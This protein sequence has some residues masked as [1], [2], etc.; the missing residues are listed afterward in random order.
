NNAATLTISPLLIEHYLDS[1]QEATTKAMGL[2]PV[3]MEDSVVRAQTARIRARIN[4]PSDGL[5]LDFGNWQVQA[6]LNMETF[7]ARAFRRPVTQEE[8]DSLMKFAALSFAHDGESRDA[9]TGLAIRATLLSP[10]FLFR[11]ERDPNPDGTGKVFEITE[12]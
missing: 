1:A 10:E 2:D 3:A 6:R 7:A 8:V 9:A 4:A 5:R 11:I 12:Y